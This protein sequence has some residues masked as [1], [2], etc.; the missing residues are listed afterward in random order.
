MALVERVC[1]LGRKH[2]S[3]VKIDRMLHLEGYRT[4]S[5]TPWPAR[6]DGRVIVRTLLK[7][8]ITP[9]PGD[10]RIKRY[11]EEYA[12]KLAASSRANR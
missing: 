8:G 2:T 1:K 7:A 12:A 11:A 5:G 3:V 6:N 4:S 10:V 9:N